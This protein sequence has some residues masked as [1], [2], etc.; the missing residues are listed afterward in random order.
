MAR[1]DGGISAILAKQSFSASA[2]LNAALRS[3]TRSR[4]AAFSSAVKTDF[5]ATLLT[6]IAD[7][8]GQTLVGFGKRV[9]DSRGPKRGAR[10]GHGAPGGDD[11]RI[12]QESHILILLVIATTWQTKTERGGQR[13]R[14]DSNRRSP[15]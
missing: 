10:L 15:P 5:F 11:P 1:S 7:T 3:R 6:A 13:P 14:A 2:L 4:I 9:H 12:R 8:S